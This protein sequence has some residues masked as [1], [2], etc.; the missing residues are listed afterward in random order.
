[1]SYFQKPKGHHGRSPTPGD[2]LCHKHHK[3]RHKF[4]HNEHNKTDYMMLFL[5]SSMQ[6][7]RQIELALNFL[8]Q[9]SQFQNFLFK[10]NIIEKNSARVKNFMFPPYDNHLKEK[11]NEEG[12]GCIKR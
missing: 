10:N 1:M 5:G 9:L 7:Q 4:A 6:Q 12:G 3:C 11:R 2:N 8:S